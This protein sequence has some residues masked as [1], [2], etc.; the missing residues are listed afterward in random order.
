MNRDRSSGPIDETLLAGLVLL[1]K[2]YV[3]LPAPPPVEL[4][5]PAVVIAP[6]VRLPIL[7]PSQLQC[8][9]RVSLK[10]F[11]KGRKIWK[12]S[13]SLFH[14]T[15]ITEKRFFDALFVPAFRQR[16]VDPC[17]R[18]FLQVVMNRRPD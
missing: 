3:L 5:E 10:L 18:R 8:Q 7:F 17:C 6:R 9:M 1:A 13:W 11:S 16:P 14:R 12:V 15:S 4:A 2:N